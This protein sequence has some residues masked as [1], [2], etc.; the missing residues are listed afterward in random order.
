MLSSAKVGDNCPLCPLHS[1]TVPW[2]GDVHRAA[3]TDHL[4][5]NMSSPLESVA[6]MIRSG[7]RPRS[8][9]RGL[10]S[11]SAGFFFFLAT[12]SPAPVPDL[13]FF[14]FSFSFFFLSASSN[15]E[16][17]SGQSR[18]SAGSHVLSSLE[19]MSYS[20]LVNRHIIYWPH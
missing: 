20:S 11:S 8:K 5:R 18:F 12:S 19:K 16:I 2:F 3:A 17:S 1:V 7:S 6:P 4:M 15:A 10:E 9:P 14:S 13:R